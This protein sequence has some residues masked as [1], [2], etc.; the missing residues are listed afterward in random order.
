VL[1]KGF[2]GG[3]YLRYAWQGTTENGVQIKDSTFPEDIGDN[4]TIVLESHI[5]KQ[6]RLVH[7]S[8]LQ[9]V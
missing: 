9:V 4:G 8:A 1:D 6:S 3:A 7:V 2:N 5:P